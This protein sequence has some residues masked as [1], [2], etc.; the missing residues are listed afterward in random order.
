MA[1][2]TRHQDRRS[3]AVLIVFVAVQLAYLSLNAGFDASAP[4]LDAPIGEWRALLRGRSTAVMLRWDSLIVMVNFVLLFVPGSV[5]FRRRLKRS[6]SNG[7]LWPDLI[8]A[9]ALLVTTTVVI[10]SVTYAVLGLIPLDELSDSVLRATI[11]GNAYTIFGIGSVAV[12]LYLGAASLAILQSERSPRW[13]AW[14]GI[15]TGAVSLA[16]TLWSISADFDG[17]LFGLNVAGRGS[18]LAWV[19]AAGLWLL[20]ATPAAVP[21]AS[22]TRAAAETG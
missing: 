7:S 10:A 19:T 14:W 22:A 12:A 11:I 17:P 18:F 3:G 21:N 5:G 16:G 9:A 6:T 8:V 20:R 2:E 4:A 1:E 13:L 15:A